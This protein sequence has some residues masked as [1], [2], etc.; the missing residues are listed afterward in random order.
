M[1]WLWWVALGVLLVLTLLLGCR[2]RPVKIRLAS[3]GWWALIF[4]ALRLLVG[5]G[6]RSRGSSPRSGGA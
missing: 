2:T 1:N 4:V 5:G 6:G 3:V